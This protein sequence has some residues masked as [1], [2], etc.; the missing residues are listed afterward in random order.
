MR[1][2]VTKQYGLWNS[3]ISPT[4]LAKGLNLTD[5]AWNEDGT[6]VWREMRS[7]RGVLVVKDPDGSGARELNNLYSTRGFVGYGGGEFTVAKGYAYFVEGESGRIY[8]Q[9]LKYG[10]AV[11]IT[12]V[13]G[14]AAS[15]SVSPD[16]KFLLYVHTYERKDS[17]ALVDTEGKH[18]PKKLVWG[19]D[20]YMQPCWHSGGRY[21]AW[22]AWNHP[23]MPWDGTK[24]MLG[25][26]QDDAT[27]PHVTHAEMVAGG[28]DVSVF[29]SEFS[30]DGRYLAYVSD[31]SGWW[32]LYL[33]DLEQK[34]TKQLTFEQAEHGLPAWVLGLRTFSFSPDGKRL[35]FTRI[36]DGMSSLWV[37]DLD[38]GEEKVIELG[39][40]Y[41]WLEQVVVSQRDG[42]IA[43]LASGSSTPKRVITY[44]PKGGLNIIS[45]SI[46]EVLPQNVFS[47][48]SHIT[49]KSIDGGDVHGVYYPPHNPGFEGKGLPPLIVLVHG[50]PTSQRGMSFDIQVQ[51]FTSRGYAVLQVNYR[52]STGYGKAYRN[53]LKGNWGIYDV[54]DS[55]SGAKHLAKQGLVDEEKM[56]IMGGSAGG[57]TVLKALEDHPGVF[58]AGICLYGVS[59]QFTLVADTHKFEERYSDSLIG[60]LPEAAKLYRDRSPVFFANR[61]KDALI[62]FQGEDDKVVPKSQSDEIVEAVRRNGVQ[63]EYHVYPG[64]GHGF[65]KAETIEHFY[66]TVEKFLQQQVIYA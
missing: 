22:I 27:L 4:F 5:V 50:G 3:S 31:E 7:G 39:D 28:D 36:K 41:Q 64:E 10:G 29:Q 62:V 44:H 37:H 34:K 35:Y 49:W 55:V 58:K 12:P 19:D 18:W 33:F 52:G 26:L 48:P 43:M 53:A 9:P 25:T 32:Q 13:F 46:P 21:I 14:G 38:S 65:R 1:E 60:A 8:R 61:I 40:T 42:R 45:R 59:N 17:I 51:F 24:L 47:T 54:D 23:N 2:V 6:L 11:P 30:P 57:F 15:P 66:K 16:G 20:F 56:V 63:C